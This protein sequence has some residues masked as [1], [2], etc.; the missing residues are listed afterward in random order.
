MTFA[1]HGNNREAYSVYVGKIR[2][3][4]AFLEKKSD[5]NP[6][7]LAFNHLFGEEI[8]MKIV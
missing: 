3:M 6:Q 2:E 4:K 7:G 1:V 5:E 8:Q